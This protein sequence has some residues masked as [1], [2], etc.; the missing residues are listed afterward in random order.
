MSHTQSELYVIMFVK[1][2][3]SYV[4]MITPKSP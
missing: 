1:N 3:L 4:M 2:L